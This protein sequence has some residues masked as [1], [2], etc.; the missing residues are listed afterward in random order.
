VPKR[1]SRPQPTR[2]P[3]RP[4]LPAEERRRH[5]VALHLSSLEFSFLHQRADRLG[6][7]AHVLARS[8]AIHGQ[9]SVPRVPRANYAVVG[10][11]GRLA[12]LL[13]QALRHV[14][15]GRL[16]SDLLPLV[17]ENLELV[18]ALRRALVSPP[19]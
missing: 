13:K 12:N 19:S 4:P 18:A 6:L 9:V 3:G 14:Q 7:P 15:A 2:S 17:E 1:K 10:Q 11:L 8:L 16:S 5:R